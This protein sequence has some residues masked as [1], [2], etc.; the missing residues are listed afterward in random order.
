MRWDGYPVAKIYY[1]VTF[2]SALVK[3]HLYPG[4]SYRIYLILNDII[5]I[6]C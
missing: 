1:N 6:N 3:V 2:E 5:T 4:S